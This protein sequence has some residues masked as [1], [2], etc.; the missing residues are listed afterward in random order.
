MDVEIR[1]IRAS[2]WRAYRE[3]RLEALKDSPLAFVE[4]YDDSLTKPDRFWQDRVERAATDP[5]SATFVAARGEK[6]V[7]KATGIVEQDVT[8]HVSA[9]IVGVYASPECRGTG[10]AEAVLTAVVR[11]AREDC[12]AGRIR[13]HVLDTNDRAAAFYRRIGF[14]P[15]GETIAYP[16]D[17]SHAEVEMEHVI[18]TA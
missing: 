10:I 1:R 9:I 3:L 2:E 13:L 17:P 14:V 18:S 5:A 4:Q 12:H 15:T 8:D 6:F 16:P 11:W 7:A